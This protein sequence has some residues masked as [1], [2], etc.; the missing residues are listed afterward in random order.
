MQF[1]T[2]DTEVSYVFLIKNIDK[3]EFNYL[4]LYLFSERGILSVSIYQVMLAVNNVDE[5]KAVRTLY[6]CQISIVDQSKAKN[7]IHWAIVAI[8]KIIVTIVLFL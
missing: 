4:T 6:V 5:I 2:V 8:R 1:Q 3:V 7:I